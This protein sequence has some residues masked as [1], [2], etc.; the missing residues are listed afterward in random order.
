M[1][2]LHPVDEFSVSP[3]PEFPFR[4]GCFSNPDGSVGVLYA[5][6]PWDRS[7][8]EG[9][10]RGWIRTE[11][12]EFAFESSIGFR[13]AQPI[14]DGRWWVVAA[15]SRDAWGAEIIDPTGHPIRRT[16]RVGVGDG[17]NCT[18]V[19]AEGRLWLGYIDEGI[20]GSGYPAGLVRFDPVSK[21]GLEVAKPNWE[22]QAPGGIS[23]MADCYALNVVS[24][25]EVWV[26]PYPDF[27]VVR[28]LH[29]K[30]EF[31]QRSLISGAHALAVHGDR[32]LFAGGYE[33][34]GKYHLV[35]QGRSQEVALLN[36]PDGYAFARGSR[37]YIVN[38]DPK[39]KRGK[40]LQ[41]AD[42][43]W[44]TVVRVYDLADL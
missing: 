24:P 6:L 38:A 29:G 27:P 23:E 25:E 31:I 30:E 18:E 13:Y 35:E 16:N 43:P 4:R 36:A 17:I 9:K 2:K 39:H 26:C 15:R 10:H 1:L 14:P 11:T 32:L 33:H 44:P 19:D 20:F 8:P 41:T 40:T 42:T 21:P 5:D 28:I 3:P 34:R 22:Y 37:M 7:P 12:V